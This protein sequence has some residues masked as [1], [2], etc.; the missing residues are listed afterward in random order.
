M[1]EAVKI[2][3]PEVCKSHEESTQ[4]DCVHTSYGTGTQHDNSEKRAGVVAVRKPLFSSV[5]P[6]LRSHGLV[7]IHTKNGEFKQAEIN[8][9][10]A[11]VELMNEFVE[12]FDDSE[13]K[14]WHH[15]PTI[16]EIAEYLIE[17]IQRYCNKEMG[18]S[19]GCYYGE[20]NEAP[21]LE[22]HRAY[23]TE[24][25]TLYV[26][27]VD[28]LLALA[29]E[30]KLYHDLM[31]YSTALICKSADIPTWES[32]HLEFAKDW[33]I[34]MIYDSLECGDMNEQDEKRER[35][36]IRDYESG[37]IAEYSTELAN[38]RYNI[39]QLKELTLEVKKTLKKEEQ[40]VVS[41]WIE[42]IELIVNNPNTIFSFD[43]WDQSRDDMGCGEQPVFASE[44][45]GVFWSMDHPIYTCYEQWIN[46][47][48][49]N[50]GQQDFYG[51]AFYRKGQ[52][53]F[54]FPQM[55]PFPHQITELCQLH[56]DVMRILT[57]QTN[58]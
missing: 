47:K 12:R 43:Y 54:E 22:F 58:D 2:K 9:A 45:F 7:E 5:N 56:W 42:L 26:F 46:E 44:T 36:M 50:Q 32:G 34:D 30:N 57:N 8:N 33:A 25:Y 24:Q 53:Q 11:A 4:L 6:S 29:K 27:E 41:R 10:I 20:S 37:I 39:G 19:I 55:D 15:Q 48:A 35:E 49:G 3:Q 28:F 23:L 52:G 14:M 51:T 1:Q 21:Q 31:L 13:V 17:R 40:K 16:S 38:P 18:F